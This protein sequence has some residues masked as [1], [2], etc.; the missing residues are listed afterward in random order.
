MPPPAVG[1]LMKMLAMNAAVFGCIALLFWG[2]EALYAKFARRGA[3]P[4]TFP[5]ERMGVRRAMA[6]ALRSTA[7]ILPG[8][9]LLS[10]AITGLAKL[11]GWELPAQDLLL[12]LKNGE[13][14]PWAVAVIV[15]YVL[16]EAPLLEELVFRRFLFRAFLRWSGPRIAMAA[17]G[18]LFALMHMNAL[19]FVP[20][21][22]VGVSFSWLYWRT[23]RLAAPM[24]AH[25]CFNAVNAVLLFLFPEMV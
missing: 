20:L 17:S 1:W 10:M 11:M 21:M 7:W 25:F 6:F 9:L 19:V 12:W 24:L 18:A 5:L 14:P 8:A 3:A 16:T 23:G 22:F 4:S 15:A 13:Y 2:V